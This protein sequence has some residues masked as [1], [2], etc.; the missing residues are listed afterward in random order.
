[1]G[2]MCGS[3][4]HVP[5]GKCSDDEIKDFELLTFIEHEDLK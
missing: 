1:M 2:N 5:F 4:K 3:T